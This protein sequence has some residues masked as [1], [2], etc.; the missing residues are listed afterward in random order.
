[1]S[2]DHLSRILHQFIVNWFNVCMFKRS[3]ETVVIYIVTILFD[4]HIVN[5]AINSL[6]D[7]VVPCALGTL[8]RKDASYFSA[9]EKS[10]LF[11][12]NKGFCISLHNNVS[13]NG[14]MSP[15]FFFHVFRR[16]TESSNVYLMEH[17]STKQY[18]EHL[19]QL[20][21]GRK[22]CSHRVEN[23]Y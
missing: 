2:R 6:I 12:T 19:L 15:E 7:V 14:P 1:M 18:L 9:E 23:F 22:R 4:D 16:F 13:S 10:E 5:I 20:F 3:S 11:S 17:L 21:I 8:C